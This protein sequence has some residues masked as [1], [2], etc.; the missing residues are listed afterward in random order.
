M[1]SS[2]ESIELSLVSGV[3]G[4]AAEA[5]L[6][7]CRVGCVEEIFAS[8]AVLFLVRGGMLKVETRYS[9]GC[10]ASTSASASDEVTGT[11]RLS[12]P[13]QPCVNLISQGVRYAFVE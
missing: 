7:L 10:V 4:A 6:L 11:T 12:S 2:S 9:V 8:A 13:K 5:T 3:G 1:K